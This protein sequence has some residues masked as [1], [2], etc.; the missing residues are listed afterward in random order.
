MISDSRA[1]LQKRGEFLRCGVVPFLCDEGL[2]LAFVVHRLPEIAHLAVDADVDLVKMPAPVG[3]LA[4][5]LDLL[6]PDFTREH[7]AEAP[8]LESYRLLADVDAEFVKKVPPH[9]GATEGT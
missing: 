2:E 5:G 3:M 7:G 8:P 4:N 6:L 9:F 1:A